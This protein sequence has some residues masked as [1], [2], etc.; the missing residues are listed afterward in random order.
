VQLNQTCYV[1]LAADNAYI[2]LLSL[3][4]AQCGRTITE[5][6]TAIGQGYYREQQS[7][8]P[9]V[10]TVKMSSSI[11]FQFLC[12]ALMLA[13]CP[14]GLARNLKQV[15]LLFRQP[16]TATVPTVIMHDAELHQHKE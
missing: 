12:A 4:T 9:V 14:I 6:K 3:Q 13:G 1:I 5:P 8:G 2:R 11:L 7:T 15:R 10:S 16:G